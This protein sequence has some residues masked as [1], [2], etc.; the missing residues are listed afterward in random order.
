MLLSTDGVV[1]REQKTG[2]DDRIVTLLTRQAGVVRAFANGARRYKN[3]NSS[4][5]A[6]LTY[7]RFV[8]YHGREKYIVNSAESLHVFSGIRSDIERLALAQYLCELSLTLAPQEDEAEPFLRLLLNTLHLLSEGK[9]D[10]LLLK[11]AFEMRILSLSG[12]MPD[13]TMCGSCGVYE[14]PVMYLLTAGGQLRCDDCIR[15]EPS[16]AAS[17]PLSKTALYALRHTVY[18]D[19]AKLFSF[20]LP[21][22]DLKELSRAAQSYLLAQTDRTYQTLLFYESLRAP[23]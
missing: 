1:I 10:P 13:L 19:G 18:C 12:H 3:Q 20:A 4:A 2:E 23:S 17:V 7:S 9:R 16:A 6:L 5:T 8:L 14:A 11:S 15:K 22:R 21:Q